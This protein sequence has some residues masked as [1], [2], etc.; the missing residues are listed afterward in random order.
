VLACRRCLNPLGLSK[1]AFSQGFP[2]ISGHALRRI[3]DWRK[4]KKNKKEFGRNI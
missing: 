2:H 1:V 4:I 3:D